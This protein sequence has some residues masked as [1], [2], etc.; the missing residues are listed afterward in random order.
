MGRFYRRAAFTGPRPV[1]GRY[2]DRRGDAADKIVLLGWFQRKDR[3]EAR[4]VAPLRA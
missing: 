1:D 2:L 3:V 4:D